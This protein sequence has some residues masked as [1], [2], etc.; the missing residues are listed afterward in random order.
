MSKRKWTHETVRRFVADNNITTVKGLRAASTKAYKYAC[1]NGMYEELGLK[2]DLR[3]A[4]RNGKTITY[5]EVASFVA[6]HGIVTMGELHRLNKKYYSCVYNYK[7]HE[8]LGLEK[9]SR[10]PWSG[11]DRDKRHDINL[12]WSYLIRWA[13]EES[14]SIRYQAVCMGY[15]K[16]YYEWVEKNGDPDRDISLLSEFR[17]PPF[18]PLSSV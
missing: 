6:E 7:M 13:D 12:V 9:N 16:E 14:T 15:K 18:P 5:E 3:G 11:Y 8:R 4:G 17:T 2:K 1:Q 10:G